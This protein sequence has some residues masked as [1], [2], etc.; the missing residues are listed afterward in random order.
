MIIITP[1]TEAIIINGRKALLGGTWL[2]SLCLFSDCAWSAAE[3]AEKEK[4]D[5]MRN[6]EKGYSLLFCKPEFEK[7]GLLPYNYTAH[8]S[9]SQ[10]NK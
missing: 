5:N 6:L 9:K 2:V 3:E 8:A 1:H 10:V 4:K 7:R